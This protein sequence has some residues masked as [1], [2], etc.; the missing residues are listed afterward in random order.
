MKSFLAAML[1]IC[2]IVLTTHAAG[3]QA[4]N[5][6]PF[7]RE[8]V[9]QGTTTTPVPVVVT[10]PATPAEPGLQ[11]WI[12]TALL[13]II[14]AIGG[15]LAFKLPAMP[16]GSNV[17]ASKINDIVAAALNPAN[18]GSILKDHDLKASVD[19]AMLKAIQSG[20]PGQALQTGLSF[21]PGA[22]PIAA[23]LEPMLRK[24]VEDVLEQRA[25]THTTPVA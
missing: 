22:G 7:N 3:A 23:N 8:R 21:I 20:I 24:I 10:A 9:G 17:G 2:I 19:V 16:G 11:S 25:K 18:A 13:A 5:P 14:A 1:A 15:K 12:H 4:T 6:D